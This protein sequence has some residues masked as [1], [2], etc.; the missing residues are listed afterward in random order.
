MDVSGGH[1]LDM[2]AQDLERMSGISQ[3][4]DGAYILAI[5]T[6]LGPLTALFAPILSVIQHFFD[7]NMQNFP[8]KYRLITFN[9]FFIG[10]VA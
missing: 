9:L 7:R 2:H 3:L 10:H 4:L 6:S 8:L 1:D 5:C